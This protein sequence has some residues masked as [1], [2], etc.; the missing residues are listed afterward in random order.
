MPRPA[1]LMSLVLPL[2]HLASFSKRSRQTPL[3]LKEAPLVRAEGILNSLIVAQPPV[4]VG[5]QCN[6]PSIRM[7]SSGLLGGSCW[8][9]LDGARC[10]HGQLQ[11][12]LSGVCLAI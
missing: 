3:P 2:E 7:L 5:V 8:E 10:C 11:P 6:C 1:R 9:V 12:C 4:V